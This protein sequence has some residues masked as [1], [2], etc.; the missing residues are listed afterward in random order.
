MDEFKAFLCQNIEDSQAFVDSYWGKIKK[1][2]QYQLKKVLNWAI[3]LEY[4]QAIL[5]EFDLVA[6]PN[7][8]IKI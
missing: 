4:V 3:H 6:T 1:D 5:Q 7:K 8:E 2:S